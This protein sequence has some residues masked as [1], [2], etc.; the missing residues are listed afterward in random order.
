MEFKLIRCS[1]CNRFLG[2]MRLIRAAPDADFHLELYLYCKDRKCSCARDAKKNGENILE[3][4]S[5]V[6]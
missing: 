2:K 1:T 3:I 4:K 5:R 6:K